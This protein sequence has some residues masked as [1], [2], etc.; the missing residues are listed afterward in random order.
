[1]GRLDTRRHGLR[2]LRLGFK[3]RAERT[4]AE[5]RHQGNSRDCRI[6]GLG[7]LCTVPRRLGTVAHL[8]TDR[9][10]LRPHP[11]AGSHDLC[12]R[13]V[14]RSRSAFAERMATR[15]LPIAGGR[16][17]RRRVGAG[18]NLCCRSMARRSSQDGRRLFADGLLRG[19]LSGRRA[20]L[21]R[22]C[23]LRMACDVLVRADANH[24]NAH[25]FAPGERARALD[26]IAHAAATS[27]ARDLNRPIC[28]AHNRQYRAARLG[29]LRTVGGL[30]F[31]RL[32]RSLAWPSAR[33]WR[34]PRQ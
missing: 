12:L 6:H 26:A 24:S 29:H 25:H 27:S 21:H 16:G 28:A 8:G 14:H 11:R 5:V 22:R 9:R 17:H 1:M 18:R 31:T 34:R 7:A 19:I 30:R 10:S 13:I 4:A 3:S 33:E 2:H 23:A 15:H 32:P 20:E